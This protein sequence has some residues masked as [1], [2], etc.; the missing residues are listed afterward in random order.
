MHTSF[1]PVSAMMVESAY[2]AN[3]LLSD[4]FFIVFLVQD[5]KEEEIY[6]KRFQ[7]NMHM[8]IKNYKDKNFIEVSVSIE[9]Q[10]SKMVRAVVYESLSWHICFFDQCT[11]QK[12]MLALV[13]Q[14]GTANPNFS[15]V[16]HMDY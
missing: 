5:I 4:S 10:S 11:F 15:G 14:S 12:S 13:P 9:F 1:K 8:E 2:Y 3:A 6:T 7:S 16:W